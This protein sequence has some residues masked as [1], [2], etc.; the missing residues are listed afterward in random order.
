MT[1]ASYLHSQLKAQGP[2]DLEVAFTLSL[3]HID[4]FARQR[5]YRAALSTLE[6]L[7]KPR[8]SDSHTD[9]LAQVK[10]LN[11]KVRLLD[12]CNQTL[13]GFSIAVR[14]CTMA[15]NSR[16]LPALWESVGI[17]SNILSTLS[18]FEAAAQLLGAIA[19]QV[20]ECQ[21]CE[22]LARTYSALVDAHMGM[23]GQAEPN[24]ATRL[25]HFH[26]ALNLID[27][28]L[29]AWAKME[30]TAGQCDMLV[31]KATVLRLLGDVEPSNVAA[32]R[33]LEVRRKAEEGFLDRELDG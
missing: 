14:A 12:Q 2:P 30:D 13:K 9:I 28:A 26:T 27:T 21:D 11:L 8:M 4:L 19:P 18:E 25:D 22:L 10:L 1:A 17:L 7:A 24:S 15:Y 31:K 23:A 29:E 6:D 16:L 32:A 20:H 3:L 33:Y 5:N